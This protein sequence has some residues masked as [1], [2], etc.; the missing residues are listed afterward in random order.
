VK[1][2]QSVP[3]PK[4][5]GYVFVAKVEDFKGPA[6]ISVRIMGKPVAV[7]QRADGTYFAREAACKHQGAD[8]SSMPIVNGTVT[9]GR[10][11]WQYDLSTG[12][13]IN[14]D[15]PLLRE[16]ETAVESGAVFVS[17]FPRS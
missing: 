1:P 12:Q 2:G 7:F 15:S 5:E 10:H 4:K 8:L 13:C 3:K 9:C 11:G 6:P 14:R 16:H 17:L